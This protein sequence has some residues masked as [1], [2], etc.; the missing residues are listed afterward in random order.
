MQ[1]HILKSIKLPNLHLEVIILECN[2]LQK[3]K[4][5]EKN[6]VEFF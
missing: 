6:L 1:V 2:D 3:G 4:Y 5:Q